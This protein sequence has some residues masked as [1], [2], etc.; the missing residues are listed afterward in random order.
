MSL[1]DVCKAE[2]HHEST[3]VSLD[4]TWIRAKLNVRILLMSVHH[5]KE[6]N[7]KVLM[8]QIHDFIDPVK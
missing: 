4:H 8:T 2:I 1:Q 7:I 6:T 3:E 5:L